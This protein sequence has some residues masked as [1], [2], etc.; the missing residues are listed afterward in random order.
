M[1]A[2]STTIQNNF[3]RQYYYTVITA[4]ALAWWGHG[5]QVTTLEKSGWVLLTLEIFAVV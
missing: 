3:G 1:N 4:G 5:G 2:S